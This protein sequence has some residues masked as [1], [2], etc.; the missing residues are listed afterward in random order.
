MVRESRAQA[1]CLREIQAEMATHRV[2]ATTA[3]IQALET[4]KSSDPRYRDPKRLLAHGAQYWSQNYEDGMIAEIFRRVPPTTRTFL[5]IGVGDGSENNTTVLLCQGW[6]GWWIDGD[7][8]CCASI[9]A[10]LKSMPSIAARLAFHEALVTPTT[11]SELLRK[12][13]VPAEVDLFS[14]DI[15]QDT[16]HIWAALHDFRPK[17]VAV[18]YNGAI[19]PYTTWIHPYQPNQVWDGTQAFG[20]SLKAFE[21]LGRQYGYSLVGCDLVGVNAF[22]VRNDLMGDHFAAPFTAENH[23]EPPR[24]GLCFRWAHRSCFFGE[25]HSKG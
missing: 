10:R 17:V 9:R 13:E 3:M 12:L 24:Y 18:E 16:Y 2:L 8:R 20:A 19:P 15:D 5:E 4:L 1:Q 23:Y 6:R 21:T 25:T 11:I 22:F 7:A 14:L